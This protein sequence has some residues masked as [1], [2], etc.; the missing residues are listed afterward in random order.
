MLANRT[1][2]ALAHA[3]RREVLSV[4]RDHQRMSAGQLAE[5]L[6]V[7]R[8]T[9]SGHLNV[10]KGAELIVGE[11]DGTTIWYRLNLSVMEETAHLVLSL[12]TRENTA[13]K[14]RAAVLAD[15]TDNHHVRMRKAV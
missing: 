15:L 7:P 9:L 8:P 2:E 11:R 14:I 5:H 3:R 13:L 4:L 10:L 12:L 6:G 1:F